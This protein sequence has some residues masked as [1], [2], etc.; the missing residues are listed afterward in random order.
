M[1]HIVWKGNQNRNVQKCPLVVPQNLSRTRS[2]FMVDGSQGPRHVEASQPARTLVPAVRTMMPPPGGD[3]SWV[4]K[5][6]GVH[7][8]TQR[9][10]SKTWSDEEF[11]GFDFWD[12][13]TYGT[14]IGLWQ[15]LGESQQ[16]F[17]R[18]EVPCWSL[19]IQDLAVFY[20]N[21]SNMLNLKLYVE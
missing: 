19:A 21:S 15:K 16:L 18:R 14:G 5:I 20:G 8:A 17:G 13:H 12:P 4:Q 6:R 1:L 7:Q 2:C 9:S 11:G 3:G 10:Q